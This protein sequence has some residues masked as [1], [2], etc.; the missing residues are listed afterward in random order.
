M[1]DVDAT[2]LGPDGTIP[3]KNIEAIKRFTGE[4]GL[5]ALAT[6]R[7]EDSAEI[8]G[9]QCGVNAPCVVCNGSEIYDTISRSSLW[10]RWLPENVRTLVAYAVKHFPDVRADA[11]AAH[12][13]YE[14]NAGGLGTAGMERR[15]RIIGRVLP[16][17]LPALCHKIVFHAPHSALVPLEKELHALN[18]PGVDYSYSGSEYFEILPL[19]INK[20]TAAKVLAQLIGIEPEHVVA[21]GDYYNDI[22]MIRIAHIGAAPEDAIEEVKK[23]AGVTVCGCG[24]GAVADLIGRLDG[25]L[26]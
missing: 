19:G 22:D 13:V 5:F 9:A 18:H 20:G 6:G 11:F 2:L 15:A 25:L 26:G 12:G 21:V 16:K 8:L 10:D 3:P 7:A 14:V 23:A 4:G 1:S 24:E 17:N